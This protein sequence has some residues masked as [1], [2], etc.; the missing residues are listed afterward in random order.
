MRKQLFLLSGLLVLALGACSKT[1]PKKKSSSVPVP[2]SESSVAPSTSTTSKTTTPQPT[3]SSTTTKPI[4][5]SSSTSVAPVVK[6]LT[7][8][9]AAG[10][11]SIFEKGDAFSFGGVVTATFSDAS[12]SNVTSESSFNGFSSEEIGTK[13]ITVSYTYNSVTKTCEYTVDIVEKQTDLGKQKISYIINYINEHPIALNQS[14]VGVDKTTKV[15]FDGLALEKFDLFKTKKE[16]GLDISPRYKVLMGD[17]TGVIVA[18]STDADGS[19]YSKVGDYAGK[20]TSK[21]TISGYLSVYLGHPEIVVESCKLDSTLS[22]TCN[23]KAL[24]K[25]NKTFSEF[26][27]IAKTNFYNCAGHGYGDIYTVTNATCYKYQSDGQHLKF[28]Y[29]TDGK[30]YI[31]AIAQNVS[32][33]ISEGNSYNITGTVSIENYGAAMRILTAE[34]S[35]SAAITPADYEYKEMS[36]SNLRKTLNAP[37]DDTDKRYEDVTLNKSYLYKYTGYLTA[38]EQSGKLYISFGDSYYGE[39]FL[40]STGIADSYEHYTKYAISMIKNDNFWNVT[41]EQA[42]KYNP[43]YNDYLCENASLELGY[44]AENF[45]FKSGRIFWKILLLPNF[46]PA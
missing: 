1:T 3:S 11:K 32:A 43:F 2:T 20:D 39:S 8:I 33:S 18:T 44:T 9:S 34:S 21:Y 7:S 16:Y 46:I 30:Q 24:S 37:Q 17:D 42:A 36:L 35:G 14:K 6:T 25:G 5:S 27:D 23:P 4:P 19:L 22:V 29:F 40:P 31:K 13:T 26:Y 10:Y 28:Y 38:V 15:S 41:E 12:T 45:E